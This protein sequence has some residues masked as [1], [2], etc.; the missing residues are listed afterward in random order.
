MVWAIKANGTLQN[1]HELKITFHKT[2]KDV[3]LQIVQS[4]LVENG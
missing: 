1:T 3:I 4:P 2:T